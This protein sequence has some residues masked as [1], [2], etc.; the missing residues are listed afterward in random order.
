MLHLLQFVLIISN[1]GL[2]KYNRIY[3]DLYLEKI[4]PELGISL[5]TDSLGVSIGANIAEPIPGA[6]CAGA[7]PGIGGYPE[8]N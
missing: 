6:A 1:H 2:H 3:R 5:E 8:K 7:I 4:L